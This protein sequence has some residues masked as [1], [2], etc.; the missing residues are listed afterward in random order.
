MVECAD[1][2]ARSTGAGSVGAHDMQKLEAFVDAC[3]ALP[4]MHDAVIA[5]DSQQTANLWRLRE[6]IPEGIIKQGARVGRVLT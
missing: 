3:A 1:H 5:Q 4:G 2:S 6:G